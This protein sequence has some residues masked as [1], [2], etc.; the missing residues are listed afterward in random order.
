M[1][2]DGTHGIDATVLVVVSSQ[3]LSCLFVRCL[4]CACPRIGL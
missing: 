3:R 1:P 4:P 2:N